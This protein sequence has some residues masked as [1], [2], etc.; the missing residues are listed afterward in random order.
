MIIPEKS[1]KECGKALVKRS[2]PV[3][4]YLIWT[5][6]M[7]LASNLSFAE[8]VA[9]FMEVL[10]MKGCVLSAIKPHFKKRTQVVECLQQFLP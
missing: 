9:V 6:L 4:A 5:V 8:M 3:L 7:K 1:L 2:T 10:R